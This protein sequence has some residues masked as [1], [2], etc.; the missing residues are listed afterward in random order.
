[1]AEYPPPA[2]AD[3][4]AN[5]AQLVDAIDVCAVR[6]RLAHERNAERIQRR[7]SDTSHPLTLERDA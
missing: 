3:L 7:Q 4:E 1:M 5:V 2:A 6:L